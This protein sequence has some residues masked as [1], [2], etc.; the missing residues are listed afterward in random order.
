MCLDFLL[1]EMTVQVTTL[2]S[3]STPDCVHYK[4]TLSKSFFKEPG[5][6]TKKKVGRYST[7]RARNCLPDTTVTIKTDSNAK[8]SRQ[9]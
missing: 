5:D 2:R 8:Q 9:K 6:P 4:L 3:L 7:L 1:K